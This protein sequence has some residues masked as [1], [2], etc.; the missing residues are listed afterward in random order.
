VTAAPCSYA[1][2]GTPHEQKAAVAA[3][4]RLVVNGGVAQGLQAAASHERDN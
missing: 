4:E 1:D 3:F 2:T